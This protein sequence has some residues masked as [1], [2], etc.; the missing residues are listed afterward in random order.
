MRVVGD[1]EPPVFE[2]GNAR[3][4]RLAVR[5]L[6]RLGDPRGIGRE[7]HVEADT[8]LR[9][10]ETTLLPGRRRGPFVIFDLESRPVRT[11]RVD[12][13]E[14]LAPGRVAGSAGSLLCREAPVDRELRPRLRAFVIG[15]R[16]A[17]LADGAG[18]HPKVV[19]RRREIGGSGALLGR[20]RRQIARLESER[21]ADG[22][23]LD[24]ARGRVGRERRGET[25]DRGSVVRRGLGAAGEP[26]AVRAEREVD[27]A[28]GAIAIATLDRADSGEVC[29]REGRHRA[30]LL[31]GGHGG[32]TGEQ[33]ID[34]S[35]ARI[36]RAQVVAAG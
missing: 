12:L 2:V 35:R 3:G 19:G 1:D 17:E 31:A 30:G 4:E 26:F 5:I 6:D 28:R 21:G 29:R 18:A 34:R 25:T 14:E 22:R 24:R 13:N 32:K 20:A 15:G 27:G 23:D 11:V 16:R 8:R 10:R 9:S 36:W 7:R 33:G